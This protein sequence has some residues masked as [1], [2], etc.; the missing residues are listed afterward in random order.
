MG[1]AP[2]IFLVMLEFGRTKTEIGLRVEARSKSEAAQKVMG[3]LA[4]WPWVRELGTLSFTLRRAL[5]Q[6]PRGMGV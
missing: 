1:Q 2:S 6:R 4:R 5:Y 3:T